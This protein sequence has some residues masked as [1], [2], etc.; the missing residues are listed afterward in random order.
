MVLVRLSI[1]SVWWNNHLSPSS[2]CLVAQTSSLPLSW[3]MRF[4][5][6][7]I[8]LV[9]RIALLSLCL[10]SFLVYRSYWLLH[11]LSMLL[12]VHYPHFVHFTLQAT[13]FLSYDIVLHR[14]AIL[15]SVHYYPLVSYILT[16]Y[17]SLSISLFVAHTSNPRL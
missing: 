1:A 17:H 12:S 10:F 13:V 3:F 6:I 14:I 7:A 2:H 16:F 11:L 15:Y 9:Y 4:Y 5:V 8:G